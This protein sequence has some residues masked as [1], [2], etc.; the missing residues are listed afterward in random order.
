MRCQRCGRELD[1]DARFCPGCGLAVEARCKACGASLESDAR[2]C[3]HCGTAVEPAAGAMDQSA[4]SQPRDHTRERKVATLLFADLV[5]FTDLGELHD[6]ELVSA[7][8]GETFERLSA[9]VRRSSS[10]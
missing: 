1:D 5:G 8:V 2:F 10:L 9:E 3:K 7:L 6:P 4:T